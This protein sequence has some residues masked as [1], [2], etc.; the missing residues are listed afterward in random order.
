[1]SNTARPVLLKTS[2]WINGKSYWLIDFFKDS[3]DHWLSNFFF[4]VIFLVEKIELESLKNRFDRLRELK[5]NGLGLKYQPKIKESYETKKHVVGCTHHES[6]DWW[7][8]RKTRHFLG[9]PDS[10][11]L[12]KHRWIQG[13]VVWA[14]VGWDNKRTNGYIG[15]IG[16]TKFSFLLAD[17]PAKTE[18][19]HGVFKQ[20]HL[21]TEEKHPHNSRIK[22]MIR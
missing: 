11:E 22:I 7:E 3:V 10:S 15:S 13:K 16:D 17:I 20:Y 2:L 5:H 4:G 12:Q 19:S 8:N 1:M 21:Q 9:P 6:W 14:V 18:W